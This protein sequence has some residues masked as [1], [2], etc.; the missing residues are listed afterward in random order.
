M[1]EDG[2]AR[3]EKDAVHRWWTKEKKAQRRRWH[4]RGRRDARDALAK[5]DF[6]RAEQR[7]KR[8]SGWLSW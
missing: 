8:T 1:Q 6:D 7:A 2:V 4:R 3:T 5:H